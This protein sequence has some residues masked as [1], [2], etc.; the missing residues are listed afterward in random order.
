ML[1][2]RA[3]LRTRRT[4]WTLRDITGGSG[5]RSVAELFTALETRKSGRVIPTPLGL[6]D[7]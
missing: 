6:V 4:S 3:V 5:K 2:R 7:S 1:T